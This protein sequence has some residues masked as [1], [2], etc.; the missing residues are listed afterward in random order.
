MT[1]NDGIALSS[2]AHPSHER[3]QS[4]KPKNGHHP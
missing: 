2:I 1:D 3:N 4:R